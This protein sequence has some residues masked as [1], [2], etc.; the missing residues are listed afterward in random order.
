MLNIGC[1]FCC[2][3]T[4][5]SQ[6]FWET[7]PLSHAQFNEFA[8]SMITQTWR[9]Y[10]LRCGQSVLSVYSSISTMKHM[11]KYTRY[12]IWY[13][14]HTCPLKCYKNEHSF[15][16]CHWAWLQNF[17]AIR[18]AVPEKMTFEVAIFGNFPE[19]TELKL[20]LPPE[21]TAC[22]MWQ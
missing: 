15:E 1:S 10:Q 8:Y 14:A 20:S 11:V 16:I 2:V 9:D 17:A 5:L 7:G 19:I 22:W 18:S 12:N 4:T 6:S 21:H 13:K 3:G